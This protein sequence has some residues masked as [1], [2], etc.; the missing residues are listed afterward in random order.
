MFLWIFI[1]HFVVKLH[2]RIPC[3]FPSWNLSNTVE[4]IKLWKLSDCATLVLRRDQDNKEY[5]LIF[6]NT[7]R[8]SIQ[9]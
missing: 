4:K 9:Y 6:I 5:N 1:T 7:V 2:N 3:L 8:S